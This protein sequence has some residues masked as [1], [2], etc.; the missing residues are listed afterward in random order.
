MEN[1]Y[2]PT[3]CHIPMD[4]A[5]RDYIL[6]QEKLISAIFRCVMYTVV[7]PTR[8]AKTAF[9]KDVY[10]TGVDVLIQIKQVLTLFAYLSAQEYH[11]TSSQ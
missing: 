8:Y 7:M 1:F 2:L 3:Q 6:K 10:S 11:G 9:G 5:L 4:K